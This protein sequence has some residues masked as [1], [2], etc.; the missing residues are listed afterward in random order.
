MFVKDDQPTGK[1]FKTFMKWFLQEKYL[2]HAIN[3]G[4]MDDLK[5]Y[6]QLN[7]DIFAY[8]ILSKI[9]FFILNKDF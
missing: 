2:R 4:T 1:I 7:N 5:G 8:Y 3:E 9:Y 6:L